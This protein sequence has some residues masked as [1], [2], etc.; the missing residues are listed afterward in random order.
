MLACGHR[1]FGVHH[2]FGFVQRVQVFIAGNHGASLQLNNAFLVELDQPVGELS[3]EHL[4]ELF[5]MDK[6]R[7]RV[8]LHDVSK[9]FNQHWA[10]AAQWHFAV[11]VFD[12]PEAVGR[13]ILNRLVSGETPLGM[14]EEQWLKICAST[15]KDPKAQQNFKAVLKEQAWF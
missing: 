11:A 14:S 10:K 7:I 3:S 4:R 8:Q 1:F 2:P 13:E 6:D 9:A 5:D 12:S 15:V